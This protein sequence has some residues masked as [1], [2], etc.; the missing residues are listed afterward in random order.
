MGALILFCA[1]AGFASAQ[2]S[3]ITRSLDNT[4]RTTLAGHLHPKATAANDQGR[5]AP[6]LKLYVTLEF[7]QSAS[8]KAD[9][10][11]LL[12][13]QQNP[14]SP[15]Y[16]RW[17]TPE[18]Y[19]DRFGMSPDDITKIT[20]WLQGQGLTIANVARGRN[21]VAVSGSAVQFEAAFQTEI[22]QYQVN[23]E[24]HFAN[25][26][27]PSVPTAMGAVVMS[28][29][30]LNDFRMKPLLAR[31]RYN[32][33]D[34]CG[35]NCLAPDDLATIYNIT[36]AYNKGVDGTAQTIAV[37][38]Q[39]DIIVSD[40]TTFRSSYGLPAIKLQQILVPG[41][42]DP[43]VSTS[44]D[45]PEADLDLE[46]SG[47]VARNAT[48]LYVYADPNYMD[49]VMT[50]VQYAIDQNLAP[51]VST[52][53]GS[54]ELE[55][56]P[57]DMLAFQNWAEQGNT[58][59]ITWFNASGDSGAADCDDRRNPGLAV[60]TPASVPQ[61]VAVGGTEFAEGAG[62][63]WSATNNPVTGASALSYIPETSWNDSAQD[64]SP[65]ASGGGSSV[66]FAQPSWQTGPG[67][68]VNNA[69][70]SSARNVPD[71]SL[72][73]S[74]DH[75][76][77]LVFTGCPPQPPC[78]P[79][80]Y[81]GTSVSAQ[82]FAGIGALMNQY[83]V[84]SGKQLKAGLGN[85]NAELYPLAQ[86]TPGIFHDITTSNNIVTSQGCSGR[87][88]TN[89][90][91]VGYNAGP[92]YDPVTGL[93]SVDVWNLI[94]GS[95]GGTVVAPAI[96]VSTLSLPAGITGTTYSQTLT[97]TGGVGPPYTWTLSGSLPPG[98]ALNQA[99]GVISGTPTT[100][101]GSPFFFSV[102]ATDSAG[103]SSAA[104]NFS[105]AIT[106]P[107][108]PAP[109]ITSVSPSSA[110]AGSP[111]VTV[112]I[113]GSGFTSGAGARL[114]GLSLGTA[115]MSSTT[116]TAQIP[117]S[118]LTSQGTA[119]IT[120]ANATGPA[121]NSVPFIIS[122]ASAGPTITSVSPSS[123]PAGSPT[124]TVTITGSGFTSSA[125][126]SLNGFS[127]GTA[128]IS[129]TT[130]TAQ[131]TASDLTSQGT[132]QITVANATGSASNSVP[133]VVTPNSSLQFLTVTPCRIMDTRNANG[134]LGGPFISG[135]TTR[136]IPIASSTCGIPANASAYSLNFT[137][138]PRG[139][140]NYLSVWPTGQ[141]QPLVS[142]LNSQDG[143]VIAN[144]AI[145]PAGTGG[146]INA[147][148]TND[149][150]LVVDIN[151]YFVPPTS[152]TLQLYTLPPCRVLD[153][154]NPAGTFGGPS[155][156]GGSSRSFPIPLGSCAVPTNA[157]AYAFNVTVVPQGSLAYLTA[158]P[159][160][161]TQP[162]VSTLNSAGG[163]VL[164]NAAIVAAGTAGAVSFYAS[165][166]TDLV[167]DI[168]G[169]F[170]P[171]VSGGL[172]FYPVTPCRLVDTRN[173]NGTFGGPSMG[174]GTTRAFPLSQGS[175][176]IP[177]S[178]AAQAYSLNVTVVPS[179]ALGY[180]STWPTT[181]APPAVS[182]LNAL[183]GQIIANAAI[184]PA[185]STGSIDVYVTNPT[186][187]VIDTNGYFGP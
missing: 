44:G 156:A 85:L 70:L 10:T 115:F 176:G 25:A 34:I 92:G 58:M 43:G 98:L 124:V 51:V 3:R 31:P 32:S 93:G 102:T 164:A 95:S 171:P 41:S 35:G 89:C 167:V 177:G 60:D 6:T 148:A 7:T 158:W 125:S 144:A 27:E 182:T 17:L 52:S 159:T 165:G 127:L 138:V 62:T 151:G 141:T 116:L 48:I 145:V 5:V 65:S 86:K 135:A 50:A 175:C 186:N 169:Y 53:Y 61:I 83:L 133:F 108:A 59:G 152:N 39:T 20:S 117:A 67:V 122:P 120:V 168:N 121:S 66:Q 38:G 173:A 129:S 110:P 179:G 24:Q 187:V 55:S 40:I 9:L 14:N 130:L 80:V 4:Q 109:V 74:A 75:D 139:A 112:T 84:S 163:T 71:V 131:I 105:I 162:L 137:V 104:Q 155:L 18:Q 57:S 56:L 78:T 37:A 42:P 15:N 114:N 107:S 54:C 184:V 2:Q 79:Q 46:W 183:N 178:P 64:G 100:V 106:V 12:A 157:V 154:R 1:L 81:G 69:I 13:D 45:L 77:Y 149:T 118:D 103:K 68:F 142:T 8:Q 174:A 90:V 87:A 143:S 160:G 28:I 185:G 72:S 21:W 99:T 153:T 140:L 30:G 147:Y 91:P 96:T 136:T 132:G 19:A 63:Y 11:Q 119:Q 150:D 97:A 146:A 82:V 123:A 23:G 94:V 166:A 126:A 47:A 180:L 33:G 88:N 134:P 16:H 128:F 111:T 170:A 161:Q 113:T 76:G 172:N 29:R 73:A 101:T 36:S 22:H 26:T 49:G 181:E